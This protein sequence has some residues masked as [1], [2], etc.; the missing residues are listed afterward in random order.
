[1]SVL[2]L[3]AMQVVLLVGLSPTIVA[4]EQ[5]GGGDDI[6]S[7]AIAEKEESQTS[8]SRIDFLIEQLGSESYATRVRAR[9]SLQR[10]GLEAF[11]D[12]YSAQ[13]HTDSEIAMTAR[14]LVSSLLVSW[15]KE[16][17]PEAVR[18]TLHEYGAQSED[19]RRSRIA[20]LAELPN[21]AGVPA[22]VRLTRFETSLSLSRVAALSLMQ[23]PVSEVKASR[24]ETVE[25]IRSDLGERKPDARA[26]LKWLAAYA[27]DLE[28]EKFDTQ[29][30]RDLIADQRRQL[31]TV[32]ADQ[33]TRSS[34]LELIRLAANLAWL[35]QQSDDALTLVSENLDLIP[36]TT[37]DLSEACAWAIKTGLYSIVLELKARHQKNF[38][39][40][41][42][43]L[44]SAAEATKASGEREE[45][46]RLARLAFEINALPDS[47]AERTKISPND[48]SEAAESHRDKAQQLQSR[49][50]F[51]WA[52]REYRTIIDHLDVV[53]LTSVRSRLLLSQMLSEL[54]RHQ[55]VVDLLTPLA[56]RAEKDE[57]FRKRLNSVLANF[58]FDNIRS[59]I[60]WHQ[61]LIHVEASE[62]EKAKL[63]LKE[64]YQTSPRQENI[65]I[66][67]S[68]YRLD[69][70]DPQWVGTVKTLLESKIHETQ[71]LIDSIERILQRPGRSLRSNDALAG[72]LNQY[73]WLVGNTD[74]D[75]QKA[76]HY[77]ERSLTLSPND[78]EIL[79][80][81]ARCYYSVGQFDK[82]LETQR[83]AVQLMPNS[84]Q[85][86]RQLELFKA[87]VE[88][89]SNASVNP[90]KS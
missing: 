73:A 4:A 20:R 71:Q 34:V 70:D 63:L 59:D 85:L 53:S 32:S 50:L 55:D 17:D 60:L 5:T 44:Y 88:E 28:K 57:E 18:Q 83:K 52:E 2:R 33:T 62:I 66:L 26:P 56:E 81:L 51:D 49:G 29:R 27:N 37:R 45:A 40:Q 36:P 41:P 76:V 65:D 46:E 7:T 79:D 87:K 90:T 86:L 72:A 84:P 75:K 21:R 14:H 80:T 35:N 61:G 10:I 31:D 19:E 58:D 23:Q 16:T 82:A 9:E 64:A 12:L 13:N 78:P 67:I 39:S 6:A 77:S 3:A 68:M 42:M 38:D 89:T 74:G 8:Q 1:M 47:E 54:Q 69:R 24:L 11:D 15:S 25:K 22:L 48:L 43:L 30:W